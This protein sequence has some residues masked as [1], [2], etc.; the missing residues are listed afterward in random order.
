MGAN[1]S[2][3]RSSIPREKTETKIIADSDVTP[4]SRTFTPP[5]VIA[6]ADVLCERSGCKGGSQIVVMD[7]FV[8]VCFPKN[9]DL[10]SR[11]FRYFKETVSDKSQNKL[12]DETISRKE[13]IRAMDAKFTAVCGQDHLHFF[14]RLYASLDV[15]VINKDGCEQFLWACYDAATFSEH[16]SC[17]EEKFIIYAVLTSIYHQKSEVSVGYLQNWMKKNCPFITDGLS[18]Y[19]MARLTNAHSEVH[20]DGIDFR[21]TPGLPLIVNGTDIDEKST[22]FTDGRDKILHPAVLWLLTATVPDF[23]WKPNRTPVSC[24]KLF[25]PTL[26]ELITSLSAPRKWTVLYDTDHH[27]MAMNRFIH[28]VMKYHGPTVVILYADYG[29]RFC[30]VVDEEWKDTG[31]YWG[32]S[33]CALIELGPEMTMVAQEP[34]MIC[35]NS[36]IRG[37]PIGMSLGTDP[38]NPLLRIGESWNKLEFR[39]IPLHLLRMQVFGT[40][41]PKLV[42]TQDKLR[43]AR[44]DY[45]YSRRVVDRKKLLEDYEVDRQILDMGSAPPTFNVD[46]FR[47]PIPDGLGLVSVSVVCSASSCGDSVS[48]KPILCLDFAFLVTL[49]YGEVTFEVQRANLFITVGITCVNEMNGDQLFLP[50][51]ADDG[52]PQVTT[53]ASMCVECGKDG[54]TRLLLTR[55]PFYKD[56]VLMSFHCDDCGYSNNELQSAARIEEKGVKFEVLTVRSRADLDRKVVK[57]DH[58]S[59]SFPSLDLEIP[60]GSQK[61]EIT[62]VEGILSRVVRGLKQEQVVRKIVEPENAAKIEEFIERVEKTLELSEPFSMILSDPSGSSFVENPRAP[63]SDPDLIVTYFA[64]TKEQDHEMGVFT[65]AEVQNETESAIKDENLRDE[66]L[67]FRTNCPECNAPCETNMKVTDIP[68]FKDVVIMAT[69]CDAC[70]HR[71]NEVKSGG[72]ISAKGRKL[73]L[74]ITD[75]ALDM[76]RDVLK[77]ETCYFTIPELELEVGPATLAGRFTTVEGLLESMKEQLTTANPLFVGDTAEASVKAKFEAIAAAIDEIVKGNKLASI[78]LDD[79][80]GNSY[81]QNVYAPEPDPHL[82]EEEYERT[83]DQN[84]ELGLNDMKTDNYQSNAS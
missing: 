50:L 61:G 27:G 42:E 21:S 5:F 67:M 77:S 16:E 8:A 33:G 72:G 20:G 19:V 18:K 53:I 46:R 43:K 23:Y 41:E 34:K 45:A 73:T 79:P 65:H 24:H 82:K 78:I 32:K 28:H 63:S 69:V 49:D 30:L 37:Y 59:V 83:F 31:V 66:V 74:D 22:C 54:E 44:D 55:I 10:G 39:K 6:L 68:F 71:T 1:S 51:Q 40:G 48:L 80:A 75:P 4:A 84:E 12:G 60:S 3:L 17:E 9:K 58:A 81:I 15:A 52:E 29:Y 2:S 25:F 38:R 7:A 36:S 76:T 70:G 13:F 11:I 56:V 14:L 26:T 64:T 57:S 47:R 35:F 62:T